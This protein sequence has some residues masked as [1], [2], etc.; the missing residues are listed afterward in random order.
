MQPFLLRLYLQEV[1]NNWHTCNM[2][3][4]Y[5]VAGPSR[6]DLNRVVHP[7]ISVTENLKKNLAGQFLYN[8]G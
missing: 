1:P 8:P 6:G 7:G 3:L 5:N 2:L 4:P